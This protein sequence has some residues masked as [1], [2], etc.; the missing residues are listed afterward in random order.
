MKSI[1]ISGASVA[2]TA[3]AHH[4]HRYGFDVTVVERAPAPRPGGYAVDVRGPAIDVLERSG[5]LASARARQCDTIATTFLDS[6]GRGAVE[7]PR[8]VGVIGADDLELMRGDL[9]QILYETP[10]GEV[11]YQFSDSITAIEQREHGVQV[12]FERGGTRGFDLVIGADG[13]HS[14]VRR[15]CFGDEAPFLQFLG[16][17]MAIFTAPNVLGLDRWQYVQNTPGRVVSVKSTNGNAELKVVLFYASPQLELDYRDVARQ[18]QLMAAAFAGSGWELPRLLP[19]M[20]DAP[21]FYCDATCQ[22]HMPSWSRGRVALVGDAAWCPSPLA[23]QGSSMALIG[24]YVLAG[25]LV[26]NGGEHVR[27]F[28]N[29][30]SATRAF[31]QGNLDYSKGL[32]DG[33]APETELGIWARNRLLGILRYLPGNALLMKWMMSGLMKVANAITLRDYDAYASSRQHVLAQHAE[34]EHARGDRADR[35]QLER[36]A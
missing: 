20:Q 11:N 28:A 26:A 5:V 2:G 30:D 34:P 25:E 12:C 33:F 21:D 32:V 29:Y 17:Y 9:V 36:I 19:F 24:A 1:L 4:L 22:V 10:R 23:G 18:R 8:G 35:A 14:N 31:I 15:L 3:L 16:N 7:M 6:S 27:A 13:V